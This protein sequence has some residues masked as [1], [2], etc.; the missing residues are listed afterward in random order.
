[1]P[2]F[3]ALFNI[4]TSRPLVDYTNKDPPWQEIIGPM[5]YG[6]SENFRLQEKLRLVEHLPEAQVFSKH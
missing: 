1:M 3:L 6:D 4:C 2:E 5:T